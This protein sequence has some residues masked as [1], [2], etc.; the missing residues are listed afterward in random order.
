MDSLAAFICPWACNCSPGAN[1]LF[2]SDVNITDVDR[3][4][5]I[6]GS[7]VARIIYLKFVLASDFGCW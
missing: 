5:C 4:E 2:S 3:R 7:P 6:N 1:Y